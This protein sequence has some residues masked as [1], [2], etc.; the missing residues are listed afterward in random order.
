MEASTSPIS[1]APLKLYRASS[2]ID[3]DGIEI[4]ENLASFYEGLIAKPVH[5]FLNN[6]HAQF[7]LLK[8]GGQLLP[9]CIGEVHK[10]NTYVISPFAQAFT[11]PAEELSILPHFWQRWLSHLGFR[12]LGAFAVGAKMD[13]SVLINSN[14]LSTALYGEL[15]LPGLDK[16]LEYLRFNF[17]GRALIFK[18]LTMRE[19]PE[20]IKRLRQLG[21]ELMMTRQVYYFEGAHAHYW[22]KSS[23]KRDRAS[24][25]K[26]IY[27]WSGHD[28]L[29]RRDSERIL[30]LYSKLY[31]DKH[32]VLNPQ[33]TRSF[34]ESA[35]CKSWLDFEVLRHPSGRIDAVIG[36]HDRGRMSTTPF[37]GYETEL[38][39]KIG[40]YRMM[41]L[42][43]L[44][45]TDERNLLLNYSSGAGEFKRRRGGEAEA[46]YSAVYVKHLST[47]RRK[48]WERLIQ[49]Y[50]CAAH[51]AFEKFKI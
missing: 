26:S 20:L 34:V 11:Y 45:R 15:K 3:W 33:Y 28:S 16:L 6:A 50:N 35:I 39:T 41:V 36:Y 47:R 19:H 31:I 21:F 38:P 1:T 29:S 22:K 12:S 10:K 13:Q 43:M 30:E 25:K 24:L 2:D 5:K 44:E 40:L 8:F 4:E 48:R 32:N 9:L 27:K 49:I 23:L 18:N 37:I 7:Q 42:R 51:Y 46:D 14:L 17:Q